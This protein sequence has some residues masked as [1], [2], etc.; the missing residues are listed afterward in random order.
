M[1]T[2]FK[3]IMELAKEK[4]R[5]KLALPAPRSSRVSHFVE[6]AEKAGLIEPVI[7]GVNG[8]G[9]PVP[10]DVLDEMIATARNGKADILFQG[11][12]SLKDF[13]D[14]LTEKDAVAAGRESMSYVSLFEL[15]AENRIFMLTDTLM[16]S[17]P[18]I[19]QKVRI[20]ENAIEFAG[21]LGIEKP[22]VA[23]LSAAE[24][25]NFNIPSSLDAAILAQM[26]RRNQLKAIIDG[27]L[28]IDCAASRERCLRKGIE[29][30]VAGEVDIYFLPDIEAGYSIAEVLT[31]LGGSMPAG[32]LLGTRIPIVLNPRCES[33]NSLILDMALASI[34]A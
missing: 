34:R 2:S 25:V 3:Q 22:K 8:S 21:A 28:D 16:Q 1:V 19:R 10:R 30:K 32:A 23:A 7:I 15:P 6:K 14:A 9:K 27:P 5:K 17:F 18:D 13:T 31:F 26:S 33:Q 20:L 29:S 4:K 24:I 12:A 11:D